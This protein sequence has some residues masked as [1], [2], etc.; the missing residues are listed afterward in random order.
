MVTKWESSLTEETRQ[1]ESWESQNILVQGVTLETA[2]LALKT[3]ADAMAAQSN[4]Q[5][6]PNASLN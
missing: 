1:D 2:V 5:R 3:I 6:P 4:M